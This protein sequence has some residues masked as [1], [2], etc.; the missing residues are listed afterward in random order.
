M[1]KPRKPK[2]RTRVVVIDGE[3]FLLL[4]RRRDIVQMRRLK[5][6][7]REMALRMLDD[8]QAEIEAHVLGG[9]RS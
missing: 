2:R 1:P 7:E 5:G 9:R 6:W 8:V 3:V 4:W